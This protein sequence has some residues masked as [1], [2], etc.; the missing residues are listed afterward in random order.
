MNPANKP[1]GTPYY[2]YVLIYV[3]DILAISHVPDAIMES[4][5]KYYTLKAGSV[6]IPDEYL[7]TQIRTHIIDPGL[8]PQTCWAMSCDRYVK[9]AVEEVQRTLSEIGQHLQTKVKTPATCIPRI[10]T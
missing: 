7:G 8:E 6:K 2:E 3:D 9:C 5:I 4:L 10:L 1:V